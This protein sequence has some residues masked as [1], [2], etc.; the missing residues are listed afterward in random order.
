MEPTEEQ[1]DYYAVLGVSPSAN[2]EAVGRAYRRLIKAVH[3]DAHSGKSD[4]A[5]GRR[6]A[7][8]VEAWK[9]LGDPTRR[10]DYDRTRLVDLTRRPGPKGPRQSIDRR[11]R[12]VIEPGVLDLG[13][14]RRGET[15]TGAI[16]LHNRGGPAMVMERAEGTPEWVSIA[17]AEPTRQGLS[18]PVEVA[19]RADTSKLAAR[20]QHRTEVALRLANPG[21]GLRSAEEKLVVTVVV[22]A[23]EPPRLQV[24]PGDWVVKPCECEGAPRSLVL[25]LFLSNEGGG[26]AAGTLQGEPWMRVNPLQF[27]PLPQ[28][29]GTAHVTVEVDCRAWEAAGWPDGTLWVSTERGDLRQ[30]GLVGR[31]H[32]GRNSGERDGTRWGSLLAMIVAS[33]GPALGL[34]SGFPAIALAFAVAGAFGVSAFLRMAHRRWIESRGAMPLAE[35]WEMGPAGGAPRLWLVLLGWAALGGA[36]AAGVDVGPNAGATGLEMGALGILAGCAAGLSVSGRD[37]LVL[38]PV[39]AL[40]SWRT[41]L[42]AGLTLASGVAWSVLLSLGVEAAMGGIAPGGATWGASAGWLVG[43][44]IAY[45]RNPDLP[46]EWRARIARWLWGLVPSMLAAMGLAAALGGSIGW[47]IGVRG[48]TERLLAFATARGSSTLV[49]LPAASLAS[50]L[51]GAGACLGLSL[52]FVLGVSSLVPMVTPVDLGPVDRARRQAGLERVGGWLLDLLA[53]HGWVEEV[54][55][56]KGRPEKCLSRADYLLAM[57]WS[58]LAAAAAAALLLVYAGAH[59]LL[60]LSA[61]LGMLVG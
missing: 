6:V 57:H 60:A 61:A 14:V 38:A 8:L 41:P 45:G 10:A 46:A 50:A 25:H 35:G 51:L 43:C 59:L 5:V 47:G 26:A 53:R 24:R 31:S 23:E 52:G 7:E 18:F 4:R 22:A 44:L 15:A 13:V 21:E 37:G 17:R 28:G 39:R 36:L 19:V 3:P 16:Q 33:A 1:K 2:Q 49:G 48:E 56:T 12:L 27:G 30:V 42:V 40:T 20:R 29:A 9:V 58:T 32:V 11:P 34:L 55:G 54:R